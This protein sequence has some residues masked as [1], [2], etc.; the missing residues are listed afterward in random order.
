MLEGYSALT[1]I[2]AHTSRAQLGTLVSGV[3]YREP[4]LLVKRA[5]FNM[6]N[7]HTITPL[8]RFGEDIIPAVTGY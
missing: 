1:Y 7:V 6:P 2:A 4:A 3:I 8:E 5:I